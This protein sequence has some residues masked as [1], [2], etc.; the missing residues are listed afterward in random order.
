MV[1]NVNFFQKWRLSAAN[2]CNLSFSKYDGYGSDLEYVT[3]S[4][5]FK[6]AQNLNYCQFKVIY[7]LS[8]KQNAHVYTL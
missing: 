7:I 8:S 5:N 3:L 2:N 4:D 6:Y 1:Q